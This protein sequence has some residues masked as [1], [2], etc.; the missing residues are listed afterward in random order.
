MMTIEAK[1]EHKVEMAEH[2]GIEP[3][4]GSSLAEAVDYLV[5]GESSSDYIR[6]YA[7]GYA[8]LAERYHAKQNA[9]AEKLR[10]DSLKFYSADGSFTLGESPEQVVQA[11][12]EAAAKLEKLAKLEAFVEGLRAAVFQEGCANADYV[13]TVSDDRAWITQ[14]DAVLARGNSPLEAIYAYLE[15]AEGGEE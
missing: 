10:E 3:F 2:F 13:L 8:E 12:I 4:D 9:E 11:R 5:E 7:R 1:L 6:T 15:Q 14:G